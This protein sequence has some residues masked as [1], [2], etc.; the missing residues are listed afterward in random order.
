MEPNWE[1]QL[2][3]ANQCQRC[4]KDLETRDRRILS[5]YDHQP[6]CLECKDA[7]EKKADFEDMT[8]QMIASCLETTNRPYGNPTSYCFHHFCPYKCK[9]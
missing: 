6:I 9:A 8:K 4:N 3:C 2:A 7:E 5:V 1:E